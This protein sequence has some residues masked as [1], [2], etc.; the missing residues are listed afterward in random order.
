MNNEQKKGLLS[1]IFELLKAVFSI[2]AKHID[3]H[4]NE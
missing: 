3:K 4:T 2:G 1:A